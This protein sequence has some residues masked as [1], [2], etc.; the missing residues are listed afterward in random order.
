MLTCNVLNEVKVLRM[1][2]AKP[3][4]YQV[5][6]QTAF[7]KGDLV[8]MPFGNLSQRTARDSDTD[9]ST[10]YVGSVPFILTAPPSKPV[11]KAKGKA[12]ARGKR[13]APDAEPERGPEPQSADVDNEQE[14][15]H[16]EMVLNSPLADK[17]FD[18]EK[19]I[20]QPFWAVTRLSR[21]S[22]EE[23]NMELFKIV[24]QIAYPTLSDS[25]VHVS[26]GGLPKLFVTTAIMRNAKKV[27][28]NDVLTLP[29][30]AEMSKVV[31]WDI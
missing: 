19:T 20:I 7:N 12:K 26:K 1:S 6:S 13:K 27:G 31:N 23:S 8:L 15:P 28:E 14:T 21:S 10:V 4:V 24:V 5:R 18:P 22:T 29:Y 9:K 2:K 11:A 16:V 17:K 30:D 25:S 3:W